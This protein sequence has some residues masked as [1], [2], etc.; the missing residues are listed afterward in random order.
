MPQEP[1]AILD[2]FG[3]K[4][5]D[6]I[7]YST[8]NPAWA[9]LPDFNQTLLDKIKE[10]VPP[11][12]SAPAPGGPNGPDFTHHRIAW[13][14]TSLKKG[15]WL[16]SVAPNGDYD[17][18]DPGKLFSSSSPFPPTYFIHGSADTLVDVKLSERAFEALKKRGVDTE[19]VIEKGAPHGFDAGAKP[20]DHKY[21]I[22]AKG[23]KFLAD[24]AI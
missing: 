14:F 18:I 22:V 1:L 13:L 20:G 11:P 8:P 16:K 2:V 17:S 23:F 21:E 5:F 12:S 6:D 19:L 15:T 4:Y 10:E 24:Y 9:K 7:S 3:L